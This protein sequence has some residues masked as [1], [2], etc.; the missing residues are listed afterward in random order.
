MS[1][2]KVRDG[3]DRPTA[4]PPRFGYAIA[5]SIAFLQYLAAYASDGKPSPRAK[6]AVAAGWRA[7]D[8]RRLSQG[9]T[10]VTRQP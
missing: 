7:L 8:E 4:R 2:T 1:H 10:A 3:G 9:L 5:L 6:A